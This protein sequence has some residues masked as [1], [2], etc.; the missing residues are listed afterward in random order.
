MNKT[1]FLLTVSMV[2]FRPLYAQENDRQVPTVKDSS[3][4]I[5][6]LMLKPDIKNK[7]KVLLEWTAK[8]V[9]INGFFIIER[10]S[11]E[12]IYEVI[13]VIKALAAGNSFEYADERPRGKNYYRVRMELPDNRIVYSPAL[14]A[15]FAGVAN[16]KFYP[17]PVDKLLIVRTDI[18]VELQISDGSGKT[19]IN[20]QLLPG[21]QLVNVSLLEKGIYV[22]ILKEKDSNRLITDK[23]I[24]N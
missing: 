21:L 8:G 16:C 19:R 5:I 2:F 15:D 6:N 9:P 22:I 14:S 4:P 24:K 20:Q 17:N 1:V 3:S 18:S 11:D 23:L 10:S 7:N 13:G 12:K